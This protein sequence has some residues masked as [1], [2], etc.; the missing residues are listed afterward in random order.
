MSF[1]DT[2]QDLAH[3]EKDNYKRSFRI[4]SLTRPHLSLYRKKIRLKRMSSFLLF[5]MKGSVTVEAS[6]ASRTRGICLDKNS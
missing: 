3:P 2:I 4:T 1:L 6:V 5:S